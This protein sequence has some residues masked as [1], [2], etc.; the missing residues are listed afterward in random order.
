MRPQDIVIL[1][2]MVARKEPWR[3]LDLALELGLS[4]SEITQGLERCKQAGLVDPS[5]RHPIKAALAEFVI[6][7]LKYVFP[8]QPGP[9]CRGVPTAHSAP[10]LAGHIV[11][12]EI[13]Q[14]V[15]PHSEGE[16]RGQA[17]QPLYP[18]VPQAA[19]KDPKLHEAL[20]L[21]DAIRVGRAREQRLAI[22]A[23]RKIM[24][25]K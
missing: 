14:Y 11:S 1:L 15:W 5:K 23:L 13:D 3:H 25:G 20:A 22:E 16:M 24:K 19:K 17:I 6:H 8:A 2:K 12:N 18:S 10:P 4:Q 7:G 9:L 21:I